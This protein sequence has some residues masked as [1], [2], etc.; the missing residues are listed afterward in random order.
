MKSKNLEN[1]PKPIT[2]VLPLVVED[3]LKLSSKSEMP[4]NQQP[5]IDFEAPTP[6]ATKNQKNGIYK[7]VIF[8]DDGSFNAFQPNDKNS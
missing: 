3:N 6:I 7:I 2:E 5:K 8:Y 1:A 4:A